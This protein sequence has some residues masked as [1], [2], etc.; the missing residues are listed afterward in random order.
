MDGRTASYDI[1][2]EGVRVA[3]LTFAKSAYRL[4]ETVLG[5]VELNERFGRARVLKVSYCILFLC[6]SVENSSW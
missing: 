3:I 1:E 6:L 5:V 2:K 4:G